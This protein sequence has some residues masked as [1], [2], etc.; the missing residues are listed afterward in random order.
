MRKSGRKK[1]RVVGKIKKMRKEQREEVREKN[2]RKC[3][4]EERKREKTRL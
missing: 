4:E 2:V 3:L 1:R